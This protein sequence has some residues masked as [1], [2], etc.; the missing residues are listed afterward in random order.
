MPFVELPAVVRNKA[1]VANATDWLDQLPALV[2]ALERE[3]RIVVGRL[4]TDA[5][6][7]LVAE[8]TLE[9]GTDAVIKLI[10]PRDGDATRNE[11]TVLRLAH[12]DGCVR[13]LRDDVDRGA[14]L[15][16]RL[17]PSLY[18]LDLPI[19]ARHEILCATAM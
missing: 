2:T 16:E 1:L 5:T 3:W 8:A 11:I 6:E 15:L 10:V 17:G 4:F 12:G 14:L 18:D 9:D 13:L 19:D 7:A